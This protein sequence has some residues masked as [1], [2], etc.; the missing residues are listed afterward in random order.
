MMRTDRLLVLI[1]F[2][3]LIGLAF[4]CIGYGIYDNVSQKETITTEI[5]DKWY[6]PNAGYPYN[7]ELQDHRIYSIGSFEFWHLELHKP[8]KIEVYKTFIKIIDER[9]R[10]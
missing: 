8:Y 1:L 7:V 4:T 6:D 2:L 10:V 3:G 9:W 5:I